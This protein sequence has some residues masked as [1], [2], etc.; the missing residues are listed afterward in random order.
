MASNT[1]QDT[2]HQSYGIASQPRI[3]TFHIRV[4]RNKPET[5]FTV[6]WSWFQFSLRSRFRHI[7]LCPQVSIPSYRFR[8]NTSAY[9]TNSYPL[10]KPSSLLQSVR[11]YALGNSTIL[12]QGAHSCSFTESMVHC[13]SS[14]T[15]TRIESIPQVI[16]RIIATLPIRD[17][18]STI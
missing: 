6:H 4:V 15:G 13:I 11:D 16:Y 12:M 5:A 14:G 3:T 9:N 1:A 17:T 18:M 7:F 8:F 2:R 10:N